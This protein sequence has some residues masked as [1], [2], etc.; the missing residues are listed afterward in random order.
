MEITP[1]RR[2]RRLARVGNAL[3]S[4][5]LLAI[6]LVAA[7]YVVPSFL[8]YE[9]YII[10]GGSM[11]GTYDKGSI[12]FEEVV[13]SEQLEVGDVITYMPPPSSG[14]SD[15]V[16]HRII[17]IKDGRDGGLVFRTQGDAN[18]H[19]DPWVFALDGATQPVVT[20]SVPYVGWAF[21][22]LADPE[23]R[24]WVIGGPAALVALLSLAEAA[25]NA[26]TARAANRR[27]PAVVAAGSAPAPSSAEQEPALV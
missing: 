8:G 23:H 13:P 25:R 11:A 4:L 14:V 24:M 27:T 3:S 2:R 1:V 10:T 19:R 7:G 5:L 18:P 6:F 22:F 15:L 17:T 20:Y 16:T 12:V 9:R 26:R 21:L